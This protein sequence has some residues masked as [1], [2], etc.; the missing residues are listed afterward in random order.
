MKERQAREDSIKYQRDNNELKRR[1]EDLIK[2]V[3]KYQQEQ[4]MGISP[5][6][7]QQ[8][9]QRVFKLQEELAQAYKQISESSKSLLDLT[10]QLKTSREEHD[11]KLR[12]YVLVGHV[13]IYIY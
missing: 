6:Q 8:L 11:E 9:N 2:Q 1:N 5:E 7:E 3:D 12:V 10:G 13:H 4:Q